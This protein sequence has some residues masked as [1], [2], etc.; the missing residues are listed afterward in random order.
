MQ[1]TRQTLPFLDGAL[2]LRL[3]QDDAAGDIH[4]GTDLVKRLLVVINKITAIN[5][6]GIRP[7]GATEAVFIG[8]ESALVSLAAVMLL[9]TL[10]WSSG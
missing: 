1:V 10:A 6:E 5:Y 7:I 9:M 2:S 4:H 3:S 8:P